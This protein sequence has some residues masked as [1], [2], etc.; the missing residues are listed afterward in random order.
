[1]ASS[2]YDCSIRQGFNFE[3]DQ[4]VLVGHLVSI[5]IGTQVL[6]ADETLTIPTAAFATGG[7]TDVTKGTA[8]VAVISSISWEG[9]YADPIYISCQLSN[10]N[11]K[12]VSVMLHTNLLNN[13]VVFKFNIY[14]YDPFAKKYFNAFNSGTVEMKG[15]IYKVGGDLSLAVDKEP[16]GEV[17]S[18]MNYQMNI[19][20]MP[21]PTAQVLNL[22]VSDT[23]KFAKTWGVTVA[24]K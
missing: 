8:V 21:Q 2:Y 16:H 3:K 17:V 10:D 19:G 12:A 9:G 23:D 22:A 5:T 14:E 1:M 4:Q 24:N 13:D 15:L 20:I 11:A 7:A 18:P 6:A